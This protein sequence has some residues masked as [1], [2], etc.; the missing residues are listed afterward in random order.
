MS[1][2]PIP[3]DSIPKP[4]LASGRMEFKPD[5]TFEG[6]LSLSGTQQEMNLSG[7]YQVDKD[8]VTIHNSLNNSTTKSK[9]VLWEDYL[10]LEPTTP[11]E[12]SYTFYYKRIK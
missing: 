9:V 11:E 7:T 10:A 6:K 8:V 1:Q 4:G 5:G 12:F 3:L 2:T